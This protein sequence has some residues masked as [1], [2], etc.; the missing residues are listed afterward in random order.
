[1]LVDDHPMWR[2]TLR[3]VLEA[4][5]TAI[6][7]AEAADG[8]EAIEKA[9]T[10]EADVVVMDI[11][12][13]KVDGIEATRLLLEGMPNTKV[14]ALSSSDE[15][16]QVMRAVQAGATGYLVKTASPDDVA[17][18]VRRIA[19]GELVFPASLASMVLDE[20]RRVPATGRNPLDELTDREKDVLAL[21]AEGRSNQAI[22]A[23]LHLSGK[24]VEGYVANIFSKLGLEPAD[25][26]HRRVRAVLAY[27]KSR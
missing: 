4:S 21:M 23:S 27:L 11:A 2:D 19:A 3:R 10:A 5:G 14:L 16:D 15:R 24:T 1:M 12:I 8:E 17:D 6:V 7:V 13:P 9:R 25:S 22:S 20:L 18:A 26:D